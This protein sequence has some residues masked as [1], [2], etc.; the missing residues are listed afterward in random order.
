MPS[1]PALLEFY[2]QL[3]ENNYKPWFDAHKQQYLQIKQFKDSLAI[4]LLK[5]LQTLD[6]D[7]KGLGINDITYRIYQDMRFHDRE[8]YKNWV[9]IYMAKKGKKSPYAGYYLH[10]E[11]YIGNFFI[12]AGLYR[13]D[14]TLTKSVREDLMYSGEDFAACLR[15]AEGWEIDWD[16]AL[17]K[18]PADAPAS[19]PV[20]DLFRLK[21]YLLVKNIDES[22]LLKDGLVDRLKADFAP[23]VAWVKLLNR[24][25]DYAIEEWGYN[26]DPG[27]HHKVER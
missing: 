23:T 14:K 25:V 7:L 18:L 8:P 5:A 19:S 22:Y 15:D 11:P 10:I 2:R 3:T 12:C 17:K 9:G 20:A 13:D 1:M 21:H 24:A 6:E 27:T 4:E 26:I 16:R